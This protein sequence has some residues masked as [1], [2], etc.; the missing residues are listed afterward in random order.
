[1][2]KYILFH[3]KLFSF[4]INYNPL[5]TLQ[6]LLNKK[7]TGKNTFCATV[8]Q[9]FKYRMLIKIFPRHKVAVKRLRP[10]IIPWLFF[11]QKSVFLEAFVI[12]ST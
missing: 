10:L 3:L 6:Q 4:F 5:C 7:N 1:M 11:Y 9:Q 12:E 8:Q 2:C